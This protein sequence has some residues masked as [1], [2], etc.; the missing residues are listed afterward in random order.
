MDTDV[1]RG[2]ATTPA[3]GDLARLADELLNQVTALRK[4][5]EELSASLAEAASDAPKPARP[6]RPRSAA[7]G[8]DPHESLHVVALQMAFAGHTR[9]QTKAELRELGAPDSD[10]V[11]DE[12]Y[13]RTEAGRAEPKRRR[14][15][16]RRR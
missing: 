10:S 2:N 5:Y 7:Q 12:V 15:F 14:W 11:V 13:D 1:Q 9:E 16:G 4:R 6:Q 3:A 8:T